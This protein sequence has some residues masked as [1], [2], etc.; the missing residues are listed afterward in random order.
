M[1][2]LEKYHEG[3]IAL[4]ACLAGEVQKYLV[5]GMY[6]EAVRA[7]RRYEGIFRKGNFFPGASGSWHPEQKAVNTQLL[8]MSKETGIDLVATN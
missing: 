6:E 2:V 5:R 1:E 3:I 8:R 4:S 7:A